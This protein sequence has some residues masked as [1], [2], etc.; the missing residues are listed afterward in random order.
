MGDVDDDKVEEE[1]LDQHLW[2]DKQSLEKPLKR[3]QGEIV[4][5]ACYFHMPHTQVLRRR[6][7][8]QKS[9]RHENKVLNRRRRMSMMQHS[10]RLIQ[11]WKMYAWIQLS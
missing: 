11:M 1:Q 3:D 5:L 6:A 7:I 2:D 4:F 10:S 8:R 9:L